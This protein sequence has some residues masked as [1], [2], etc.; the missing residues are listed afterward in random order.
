MEAWT[1]CESYPE[2]PLGARPCRSQQ[3]KGPQVFDKLVLLNPGIE[4]EQILMA[5]SSFM[6]LQTN[7][8]G[9][10]SLSYRVPDGPEKVPVV[11]IDEKGFLVPGSVM[12]T[13]TI[14]VTAQEHFGTNQTIIVG[15]KV[16]GP[17]PRGESWRPC[18]QSPSSGPVAVPASRLRFPST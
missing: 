14:E 16:S 3:D 9:A 6:K 12:G 17:W 15:V 18:T 11:H 10:A 1:M 2:R 7:R 4:A 13:S 8:D 5:P